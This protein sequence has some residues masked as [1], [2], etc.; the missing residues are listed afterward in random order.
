MKLCEHLARSGAK[1]SLSV[2]QPRFSAYLHAQI[3][4]LMGF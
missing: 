4:S 1:V 2:S 3:P